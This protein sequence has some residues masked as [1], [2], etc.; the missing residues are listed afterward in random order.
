M[1]TKSALS[2][3]GRV[4]RRPAAVDH[5]GPLAQLADSVGRDAIYLENNADVLQTALF[6]W[7]KN[8]RLIYI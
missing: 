4:F 1:A 6:S 7:I 8:E 5:S 3:F 2:T